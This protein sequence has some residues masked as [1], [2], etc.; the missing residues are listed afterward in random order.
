[1]QRVVGCGKKDEGLD[2]EHDARERN[3]M[4]INSTLSL[5]QP[6]CAK[7]RPL[8]VKKGTSGVLWFAYLRETSRLECSEVSR[9]DD[10]E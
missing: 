8:S 6:G 2:S 10:G 4:P 1:M 9:S 5:L 7:T 3:D